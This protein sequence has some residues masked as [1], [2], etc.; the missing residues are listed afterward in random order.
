MTTSDLEG[1]GCARWRE[2]LSAIADGEDPGVDRRL[3]DAHIAHCE[4]CRSFRDALDRLRHIG[5]LEPAPVMPDL[6]RRIVKLNAVADRMSR[7]GV[8]RGV[9][10]IVAAEII[11]VSLPA[12]VLGDEAGTSAH[13]ARHLGAFSVAYAVGLLVVV[14]R[15]A[16]ARTI[17]PVA[18]VLAAALLLSAVVDVA[19]GRVPLA[20]EG[21]H[22]PELV[23]VPL[24]WLLATPAP[25][26][27][28]PG[29][30]RAFPGTRP[31][32]LRSDD[33]L[34]RDGTG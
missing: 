34:P 7:W 16:R 4:P 32:A 6:S 33:E 19:A 12:L 5:R 31:K 29:S 21:M 2:A 18:Q 22:V 17:L 9:L 11:V 1:M 27:R 26:S 8:V 28:L 25:R 14:A 30:H 10:A 3:L 23:S 13:A 24:V 15:P 20:G